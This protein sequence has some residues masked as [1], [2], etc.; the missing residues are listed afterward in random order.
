L[1]FES[2]EILSIMAAGIFSFRANL[3]VNCTTQDEFDELFTDLSQLKVTPILQHFLFAA[4][5]N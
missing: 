1:G 3:I 4:G 5:V 2:L